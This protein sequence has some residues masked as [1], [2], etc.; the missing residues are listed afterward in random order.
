M[1][2]RNARLIVELDGREAHSTATQLAADAKRQAAL[3]RWG[4]RVL[5]FSWA[6]VNFEADRVAASV[7][8]HL[9]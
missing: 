1:L 6:Q 4:F 5:R 9:L 2:W 7:R 8:R 3:E